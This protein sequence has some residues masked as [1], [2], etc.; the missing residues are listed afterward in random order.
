[1]TC[2][3]QYAPGSCR[4]CSKETLVCESLVCF[5]LLSWTLL[6]V[7]FPL[8]LQKS[9]GNVIR[10]WILVICTMA[11]VVV[12][13]LCTLPLQTLDCRVLSGNNNHNKFI[14]FQRQRRPEYIKCKMTLLYLEIKASS[15]FCSVFFSKAIACKITLI[16][17]IWSRLNRCFL[18]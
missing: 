13:N 9:T 8:L 11:D 17:N 18:L 16:F 10:L 2:D 15:C 1:M 6:S 4:Q 12:L 3:F 7:F 14:L 5:C